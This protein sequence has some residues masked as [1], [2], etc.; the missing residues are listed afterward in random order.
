MATKTFKIGLSN[1]D[2]QNMAQDIYERVIAMSFDEY[3]SSHTYNEGD[4]VVYE[5][6]ANTFKLYKC[7]SDSVTGAWDSSKWDL[8]TFQTLVD[9]VEG[10]VNS[11]A[12]KANVD[13]NYPTMTVGLAENLT[14][15]SDEAGSEQDTP[16]ALQGTGCGNGE[17]SVDTGSYAQLKEKQGNSVVVNNILTISFSNQ[18]INGITFTNNNDGSITVTGTATAE[19]SLYFGGLSTYGGLKTGHK[20]LMTGCVAGGGNNTYSLW[21]SSNLHDYGSNG[22]YS[23]V[24]NDNPSARLTIANGYAIT[25]SLTFRPK[26]IDLTLWFGSNDNIPAYLLAHPEAF[27]NYYRGSLATNGGTLTNANGQYI[28]CIGR[29]VWDEEWESGDLSSST[30]QPQSSSTYI[31]SKNFIQCSPSTKYYGK[32]TNNMYVFWYD[33]AKNYIGYESFKNVVRTAPTNACFFKITNNSSTY[34]NDITISRAY[35]KDEEETIL[36]DGYDQY[37]P[38]EVLTNN[39][40]GTE[41]LRSAGSIKDTKAPDG[42]ITRVVG[43]HTFDGV[44]GD[45]SLSYTN[46]VYYYENIPNDAKSSTSKK[47]IS[48]KFGEA[49]VVTDG[50]DQAKYVGCMITNANANNW[51]FGFPVGTTKAQAEAILDGMVINYELAT[52]TTET[53]TAFSGNLNI[54]DFG[55][56]MF[57]GTGFNGVPQ[58]ASIFYPADYKAFLDTFYNLV[59]GDADNVATQSELEA[60]DDK[61][62]G[63]YAIMQENTGGCLRQLL[64]TKESIDFNNT[65]WIDLGSL[66]WSYQ[67]ANVT[68]PYG[69]FSAV[70]LPNYDGSTK[71]IC[72]KYKT[73]AGFSIAKDT[74]KSTTGHGSINKIFIVDSSYTDADTFKNAMKGILLAYEKASS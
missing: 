36:E 6:P 72:T 30:G 73:V 46:V 24:S 51:W 66:T 44:L 43:T 13:G 1:T 11:V 52:P 18:T 9:D 37:Y 35:Y 32:S 3:D 22:I 15:Y 34:N 25:G 42:T 4:F 21:C 57:E 68:Y 54:D 70:D 63:L 12:D 53:G 50:F 23:A 31:R 74:D 40:T 48:S 61:H 10:A 62:D 19:A 60:V 55:E 69:Y 45:P 26:I 20:Y 38:Y 41:T 47:A 14:P 56:M 64:A 7:N 39:D 27:F 28:K 2:K 17:T 49:L 71:I 29:N 33:A 67:A 59:D 5:N 16:F 58:G 65:A 8:A